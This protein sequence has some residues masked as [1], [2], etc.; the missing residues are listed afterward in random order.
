MLLNLGKGL[1]DCYQYGMR[2][3]Q[4]KYIPVCILKDKCL[5]SVQEEG[6]VI[7]SLSN[8]T[9]IVIISQSRTIIHKHFSHHSTRLQ[10]SLASRTAS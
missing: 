9:I 1:R 4:R 6:K 2:N 3:L 7:Y 10:H 8:D 5:A